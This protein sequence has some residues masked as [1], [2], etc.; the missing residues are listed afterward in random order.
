LDDDDDDDDD[1]DGDDDDDDGDY[2][3]LG[4]AQKRQRWKGGLGMRLHTEAVVVVV[5]VVVT[6]QQ[7]VKSWPSTARR[8]PLKSAIRI[9]GRPAMAV[10]AE[11]SNLVL[12]TKTHPRD[13]VLH[14]QAVL[15]SHQGLGATYKSPS[16]DL[17]LHTSKKDPTRGLAREDHVDHVLPPQGGELPV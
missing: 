10:D 16:I 6:S 12:H 17:V 7:V 13:L 8:R 2:D 4:T 15:R 5:V 9:S 11:Q 1:D 14:T 3:D